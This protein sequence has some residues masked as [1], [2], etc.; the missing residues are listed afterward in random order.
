MWLSRSGAFCYYSQKE[1]RDLIYHTAEDMRLAKIKAIR[2][3]Q[4][5]AR[6]VPAKIGHS[7]FEI[8]RPQ[9]DNMEFESG[10]FAAESQVMLDNHY[11]GPFGSRCCWACEQQTQRCSQP[12][13]IGDYSS[14]FRQ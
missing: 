8:T 5:K 10:W 12:T 13:Q 3:G 7:L 1:N 11:S 6:G 14:V 2:E 9:R 4:A